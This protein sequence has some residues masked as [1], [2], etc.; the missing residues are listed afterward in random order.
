MLGSKLKGI[1]VILGSQSPRRKELL[2][3]LDINFSVIVKSVDETIPSDVD[4]EESASYIALKKLKAFDSEEFRKHLIITADTVVVDHND[5]VLGKP[6]SREEAI[7]ILQSLSGKSHK[8]LTGVAIAYN[9]Q[10]RNFTDQTI[11]QFDSLDEDEIVYYVDKYKP[12][13]KAGAYGIQEWIGRIA[14]S[15]ID[16]SYENVVGLPTVRLYQEIKEM[17]K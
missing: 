9:Q 12:Y 8:V 11:V 17:I 1:Q 3:S 6:T 4:S 13:D 10:V 5:N 2:A 14:V 15:H 7:Q 16:G